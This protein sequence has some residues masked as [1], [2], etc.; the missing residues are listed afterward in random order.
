MQTRRGKRGDIEYEH[1]VLIKEYGKVQQ[2]VSDLADS[3][4]SHAREVA[5]LQAD[6]MRLRARVIIGTSA[7]LFARQDM[8]ALSEAVPGLPTRLRLAR[9]VEWLS[10]RIQDLMREGLARQWRGKGRAGEHA[11]AAVPRDL[12]EKAVLCLGHDASGATLAQQAIA[13]AIERAGGRF[14]HHVDVTGEDGAALERS[15]AAADLVICQAGCVSH[16]AYWRV[17]DHCRRTG[18]QCVLVGQPQAL[19]FVGRG[20]VL[21]R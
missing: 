21:P 1:A 10:E 8:A 6:V 3:Q 17:Q 9:R 2:R 7:L 18:K 15:L 19:H 12:R 16:D 14:L 11:A 13:Q 20:E 4:A 5:A